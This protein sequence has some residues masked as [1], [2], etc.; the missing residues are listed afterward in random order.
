MG[1]WGMFGEHRWLISVRTIT[2][3]VSKQATLM[4][5]TASSF[6]SG[7]LENK[8]M[9]FRLRSSDFMF[10]SALSS[11]CTGEPRFTCYI[12]QYRATVDYSAC[13]FA[14][15]GHRY[16]YCSFTPCCH[17]HSRFVYLLKLRKGCAGSGVGSTRFPFWA[18]SPKCNATLSETTVHCLYRNFPGLVADSLTSLA[19]HHSTCDDGGSDQ[20]FAEHE[21]DFIWAWSVK[22]LVYTGQFDDRSKLHIE[23]ALTKHDN[24]PFLGINSNYQSE[25][26]ENYVKMNCLYVDSRRKTLTTAKD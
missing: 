26:S 24:I 17:C 9:N 13:V 4:P 12:P 22:R 20:S 8:T 21:L 6:F 25:T 10:S 2:T 18:L 19:S 3:S 16:T 1:I 14:C 11:R 15:D 23:Y 5:T 7:S